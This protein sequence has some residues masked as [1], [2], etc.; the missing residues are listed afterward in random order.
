[1]AGACRSPAIIV[2]HTTLRRTI[3]ICFAVIVNHEVSPRIRK[4]CSCC[5]SRIFRHRIPQPRN[6]CQGRFLRQCS[7]SAHQHPFIASH[8]FYHYPFGRSRGHLHPR[9][10]LRQCVLERLD[11]FRRWTAIRTRYGSRHFDWKD[12]CERTGRA[13]R[14]VH[15]QVG[16]AE[17][18]PGRQRC[19]R[20]RLRSGQEAVHS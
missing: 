1:M 3:I 14:V 7:N 12:T 20:V 18:T 16:L 11:A 17:S 4:A 19:R 13:G 2:D 9:S 10:V 6:G 5:Y 15:L 8:G